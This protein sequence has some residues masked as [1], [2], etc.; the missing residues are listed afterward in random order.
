MAAGAGGELPE[1][2]YGATILATQVRLPQ[3]R[4]ISKVVLELR[5]RNPDLG[6]PDMNGPGQEVVSASRDRLV[7]AV[8]RPSPRSSPTLP[9][10]EEAREKNR[11]YLEPN[12]FIQSDDPRL[13]A[14]AR[15]IAGGER[16]LWKAAKLL[17]RWVSENMTFDMGVVLAPSVEVFEKRRGTCTEYATLLTTLARAA[18][19]PARYVMG[20]VY[21]LGMYGGHAWTEVRVGEDWIPLDGVMVAEGPADAARFAFVWSAL[22]EGIAQLNMGAGAK[23]YGQIDLRVLEYALD[24]G[25]AVRVADAKEPWVVEGD[26]YHD[27]GL[28]L[29]LRKPAAFR[30]TQLGKVWPDE[31]IVAL[32]GPG[33]QKASLR[34]ARRRWFD[35]TKALALK[36]LGEDVPEGAPREQ[37]VGTRR[38]FVLESPARAAM[39]LPDGG[40]L[41]LLT[42]EGQDAPALLKTLAAGLRLPDGGGKI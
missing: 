3:A 18:G 31:V 36:R 40:D 1:E 6:W 10:S 30:F 23:L 8:E 27:T 32:E 29:D 9:L 41:W 20:Y 2:S 33:G 13:A 11:L 7:L 4:R 19:I 22:D 28:G 17:E 12:A 38:A 14:T 15:E 21:V 35:D 5:H 16:D 34:Q 37:Q 25:P 24:G 42:V 39:A 26:F